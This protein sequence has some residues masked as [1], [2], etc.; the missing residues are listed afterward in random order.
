VIVP[1]PLPKVIVGAMNVPTESFP[2]RV[3]M[4]RVPAE[5]LTEAIK[6]D[7]ATTDPLLAM[8][9]VPRARLPIVRDP[10][11]LQ[12]ESLPVTRTELEEDP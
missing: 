3:P 11:L 1:V 12:S 6:M 8:V 2:P 4:L 9:R 7:P 5:P 10:L